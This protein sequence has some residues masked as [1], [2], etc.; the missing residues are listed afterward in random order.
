MELCE[1]NLLSYIVSM[2]P[3][4]NGLPEDEAK[5]VLLQ[6]CQ[7]LKYLHDKNIVHFDIK[8]ANVLYVTDKTTGQ[9]I[10]KLTDFGLAQKFDKKLFRNARTKEGGGTEN[11]MAPEIMTGEQ[12][13]AKRADIYSLGFT[14]AVMVR[15]KLAKIFVDNMK[16]VRWPL[17]QNSIDYLHSHYKLSVEV[18]DLI[19]RMT[20]DRPNKRP[21]IDKVMVHQWL[22]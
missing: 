2:E 1:G 14:L 9:R 16:K 17:T 19:R 8:P 11:Y 7:G 10:Y 6:I 18:A 5:E 4:R 20:S 12:F 3:Q 21:K 13:S 22:V 15:G